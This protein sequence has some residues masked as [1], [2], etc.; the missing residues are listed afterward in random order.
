M[1]GAGL[2]Y[3]I[4]MELNSAISLQPCTEAMIK[5]SADILTEVNFF[6][7]TWTLRH[8]DDSE[9]TKGIKSEITNYFDELI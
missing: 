5:A 8:D 2:S 3:I 4:N 6:G 9:H 1:Q 7:A